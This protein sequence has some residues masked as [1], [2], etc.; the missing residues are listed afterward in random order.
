MAISRWNKSMTVGLR[1]IRVAAPAAATQGILAAGGMR[2]RCALG[3]AGITPD[4]RE[5]D[6][7][8]P[9]GAW[10]L[11]GVLYRADRIGRPATRLPVA[12][13]RHD[14]G[15]CDDPGDRRYNRPIGLPYAA[16][17]ERLWRDD[18]LYDLVVILDYNLARPVPGRGS[19]I[20]LHLAGPGLAPTAG[21]VAVELEPMRR[22][23]FFA[24]PETVMVVG[25]T[26]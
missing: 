9:A 15:W 6:G 4:K 20:F 14:D 21:C 18:H 5:G 25:K 11:V 12:A 13:V 22:L 3:R 24:R 26:A 2:V 23:L 16:S 19:A 7:G 1:S 10:R 17:H 8:T